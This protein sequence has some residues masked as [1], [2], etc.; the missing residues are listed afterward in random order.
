MLLFNAYKEPMD[1]YATYNTSLTSI[2]FVRCATLLAEHHTR[3]CVSNDSRRH[4]D[5]HPCSHHEV[6][7]ATEQRSAAHCSGEQH[8]FEY[9]YTVTTSTV[10]AVEHTVLKTFSALFPCLSQRLH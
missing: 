1:V 5:G 7:P 3:G 8:C 9:H 4:Q 6:S 2:I 10:S